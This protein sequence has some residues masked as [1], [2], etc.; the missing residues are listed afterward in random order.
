MNQGQGKQREPVAKQ[1]SHR[2]SPANH[3]E[4]APNRGSVKEPRQGA[5]ERVTPNANEVHVVSEG[6][7]E[8]AA[9]RRGSQ[10]D[11]LDVSVDQPSTQEG[12]M[13]V[14]SRGAGVFGGL[15]LRQ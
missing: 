9:W 1:S 14:E 12:D 2:T 7:Q 15:T 13:K 11:Q 6:G 3:V 8:A 5:V 10:L 4:C